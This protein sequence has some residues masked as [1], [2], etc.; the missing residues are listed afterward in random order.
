MIMILIILLISLLLLLLLIIIII[1]I[2]INNI[3]I[4]STLIR[5]LYDAGDADTNYIYH[6]ET[7]LYE[8][9]STF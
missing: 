5:V 8:D 7:L 3:R 1:M 9:L 2:I 6:K 4:I